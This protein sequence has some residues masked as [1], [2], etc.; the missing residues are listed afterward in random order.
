MN[1]VRKSRLGVERVLEQ[2]LEKL[3][4]S[5]IIKLMDAKLHPG[6]NKPCGLKGSLLSGG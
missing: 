1:Y 6:F 4:D 3:M 5:A 2:R